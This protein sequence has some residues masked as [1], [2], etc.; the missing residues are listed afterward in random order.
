MM[1]HKVW[2]LSRVGEPMRVEKLSLRKLS[3]IE[4]VPLIF[5]NRRL[6]YPRLFLSQLLLVLP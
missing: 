1:R 3:S 6:I 4:E 5:E 2:I